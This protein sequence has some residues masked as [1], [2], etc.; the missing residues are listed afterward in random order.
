MNMWQKH[1]AW[2]IAGLLTTL[3]IGSPVWA[4]DVELL[5]S[6]PG[7]LN[8]KPNILFILDSSGSMTTIE[9]TQEPYDGSQDYTGLCDSDMY[10]WGTT[11]AIP[12]CGDD[13][14]F[15]KSVFDCQQGITQAR[16]SGSFTDTMTM[17]RPNNGGKKFKWRTLRNNL[18]DNAVECQSDS[19]SHGSLSAPTPDVYVRRGV[20]KA[21]L[22]TSNAN[23]E[24]DWGSSPTH[25]IITV[26]DSNYL[27]WYHNAPGSN[28][29]RSDI[30]KAVTKNVLGSINNANVGFMRFHF[31]QGGPIMHAIKDLDENRDAAIEIV[32]NLPASG[33]TPLS[34]TMYEAALYWNG[35]P[36]YY[37]GATSTDPDALV[38][39]DPMIYKHPTEYSCSKNYIVLLTDGE[40]T[41]DTDAYY[42][43]PNLPNY[44]DAMAGATSCDGGN[45]SGACLDDISE[46]LSK[47]DINSNVD[48]QQSVTT[49][50]IGFTVD[51]EILKDTAESSGGEYYLASDV[52]S[53]TT[54]LTDIVTNIFDRDVSFTAPA[55]A[56]N[57]LNRTQHLND[58]Y[59]STF[60][61]S[62]GIHWPGN[63][64]K[65]ELRDGEITDSNELN[66][67]D[68]DT[69]Y[70]ADESNE[71]WN[72]TSQADGAD[73]LRAGAANLVPD[74]AIRNVYTNNSLGSLTA[75]GNAF[76]TANAASFT[77]SDFALAGTE[78]EPSME[79]LI[80]WTRGVDIKDID[81]DP[82][83]TVRV[84]MGDTLHAQPATV[85]YGDPEVSGNIVLFNATNDGFLHA[86]DANTGKELWSFIPRELFPNLKELYFDEDVNYKNYGLDGDLVPI[87]ADLNDDGLIEVGTDFAYL[88]FGMRRGGDNYYL[89]DVT[90][91]NY[92][93]IK[94]VRTFAESG[95]S[96]SP[97]TVAK[98]KVNSAAATGS[99]NAVLI[100]GGGYDTSHDTA[101]PPTD[102]DLEGAALL[103]LD[104]ET[105]DQIWSASSDNNADLP[106]DLMKRSI[107][108]QIRVIDINGDSFADRMYAADL[109]GQVWRF[110]ITNGEIPSKLIAGGVIASLGA[111]A[112]EAPT[113]ADARRFYS[114]PD[115]A[116]FADNN[117]GRRFLSVSLGSGY[118]AHPLDK[119]TNDRFYS[120]RDPDIFNQ[121]DQSQ[122]DNYS[123]VKDGDLVEVQGDY[124]TEI[125]TDGRGWK[126]T[127]P[128]NEK[129]LASS[130][131]FNDAIYFVTFEPEVVT[132][133]P[134]TAGQS[135]NR[136]YAVNVENGDALVSMDAP[137]PET[138]EDADA[139]RVTELQQGGIAPVPVFL[140]P[141]DW[142]QTCE[143]DSCPKPKPVGCV[144]VECFD[145]DFTNLPV[146]TLWVQDGV[147]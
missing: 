128:A 11:T 109:G 66:A 98:V 44:G 21:T 120:L 88:V 95:Q 78:G 82:E 81:N 110:D 7:G 146:R 106:L 140:F 90:D 5:L 101:A 62:S 108:S 131:T 64:K 135:V 10:Y 55:V 1:S 4:D 70:F 6:T 122:Y 111:D 49:Y 119:R 86:I 75:S 89:L 26:F 134:C 124:G 143:G 92:P 93:T 19:G 50:T 30:V 121:L 22:Y 38:S 29:S 40:P 147:E 123:V 15:K 58:L 145:P 139:A 142:G 103:M 115:V 102:P 33:Y 56:V 57:A 133:D 144:G 141:S 104:L 61:P 12:N 35:L 72:S 77:D 80:D 54:A 130:R 48:G 63:V 83:T 41:R 114:T 47:T 79:D 60:R 17:Y 138:P 25:Q 69:G 112:L 137:V 18:Q 116:M 20:D 96:W 14:K 74:P 107:P 46:Y 117:Q 51:L 105:G 59:I 9:E 45:V 127:I 13:Y 125:A 42:K 126:F 94:W 129:V 53:L 24:V 84:S 99:H 43:V 36:E 85:V 27:N 87:V 28:M 37:G 97:P 8:S 132:T 136:L 23:D 39:S 91:K 3:T 65:Y 113:L 118:R 68:P 34:E 71:Y 52:K 2:A 32:D 67:I 31:S 100:L 73:V 76:S 16:A